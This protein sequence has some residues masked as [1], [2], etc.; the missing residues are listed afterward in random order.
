MSKSKS[1]QPAGKPA[2]SKAAPS[3]SSQT[4]SK[5]PAKS[6]KKPLNVWF[7]V[8]AVAVLAVIAVVA[9]LPRG[10]SASLPKEIS[11]TQAKEKY[12]TGAYLLDVRQPQDW[13]EYHI[14]GTTLIPLGELQSRVNE[15][16][17]DKEIVVVCRSG[18]RSQQGRDIL[19]GAGLEQVTSMAGGVS[20]WR[21]SGYPTVSGP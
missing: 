19:L 6:A 18:N 16:P 4:S 11:V 8:A 17:K 1:K 12:D 5:T 13:D 9:F 20:E 15:L 10:N 14:P 2:A 21:A 7:I 3:K